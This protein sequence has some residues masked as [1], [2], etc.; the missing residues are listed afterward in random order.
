MKNAIIF[1]SGVLTGA[2][3]IFIQFKILNI[4]NWKWDYIAMPF[5]AFIF[6]IP[7][8]FIIGII[9]ECEF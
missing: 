8:L 2:Q 9:A 4:I 1:I 3:I 7:I 6:L 5:F